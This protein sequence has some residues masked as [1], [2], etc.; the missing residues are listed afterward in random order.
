[1]AEEATAKTVK[2][3]GA[4]YNLWKEFLTVWPL[5]RLT[6]MTLEEYTKAGSH[7]TFAYWVEYKLKVFGEISGGSGR[8]MRIFSRVPGIDKDSTNPSIKRS[9][10]YGWLAKY[11]ATEQ[12]AFEAVRTAVVT[13]AQAAARGDVQTIENA[14]LG[15]ALKWKIA[16]LYQPQSEPFAIAVYLREALSAFLDKPPGKAAN[17]QLYSEILP[18]RT[19]AEGLIE[20]GDRVWT[21]WSTKKVDVWKFS[22]GDKVFTRDELAS[23]LAARVI[24]TGTDAPK[25]QG[26]KFVAAKHGTVFFLCHS[27]SLRL[28]GRLVGDIEPTAKGE[29]YAQRRYKVLKQASNMRDTVNSKRKWS[30]GGISTFFQVPHLQLL[31]FESVVLKPFFDMDLLD[32]AA[33]IAADD[34]DE[35]E[36]RVEKE[37]S[38]TNESVSQT[39]LTEGPLNRILYGPPGTGKTYESVAEAVSIVTGREV[40]ELVAESE[41][42]KTKALFDTLRK[43]GQIDFV[44]FHPSYSYQDFVQGIRP[45]TDDGVISYDVQDGVLM[46]IAV[47]ARRNWLKSMQGREGELADAARF[48]RA[49]DQVVQDIEANEAGGVSAKLS[50]GTEVTVTL[51]KR[52][53]G[54]YVKS[55]NGSEPVSLSRAK[56]KAAWAKRSASSKVTAISRHVPTYFWAVVQLL[57]ATDE[58]LGSA[59]TGEAL[60]NYVLVID[61][62]NRGNIAKI[63]G[64]LITLIEDDKR[65]GRPNQLTARL[66]YAEEEEEPFGLPPNLFIVGTMNTADHSIAL[67]DTALRRRF[68][69]RELMP[70]LEALPQAPVGDVDLPRLLEKLNRRIGFLFDREHT[71]GHAYFCNAKSFIDVRD[72]LRFKVIP[73]LQ[74]YF[75]DDWSKIQLVFDGKRSASGHQIVTADEVSPEKLF[76]TNVDGLEPRKRYTVQPDITLAMVKAIYE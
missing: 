24:V 12:K 7:S 2:D 40:G 59:S 18:H 10:K 56:L 66:P 71:I 30:P 69:F 68:V 35:D 74:E 43:S 52:R 21:E 4:R 36:D 11:G 5:S 42:T 6:T 16:F 47:E 31:E 51:A 32:L 28:L 34:A 19:S 25:D 39:G 3:F 14:D 57:Q 70:R 37:I 64:E 26:A 73:L 44:T 53:G 46:R 55:K 67:M 27:N 48:D 45:S 62:I 17:S 49:Y 8:T 13:V 29:P 33:L 72:A 58:R 76:G 65:L 61:E 60:K 50:C 22:H 9:E 63:F 41:Y 54:L 1:M 38:V 15:N 75:H 20:F 23:M